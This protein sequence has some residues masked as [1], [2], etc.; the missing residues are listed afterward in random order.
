METIIE[1]CAGLDVHKDSIVAC[2]R[3]PGEQG[4]RR[5]VTAT[6]STTTSGLLTLHDWLAQFH[7]TIVAMESTGVYWKPIYYMLEDD[8]DCW[9]LNARHMRNVPG[10]KTDVADAAWIAQL[11][12]HG[13]ARPSFVPPREIRELRD[14]TRIARRSSPN[15][16]EKFNDCRKCLRTPAS[17]SHR[18][19]QMSRRKF[20]WNSSYDDLVGVVCA[21]GPK[22][23]R[24]SRRA[25]SRV[26][27]LR[28][29]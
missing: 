21:R 25:S 19:L 13:L 12:E 8:F 11:L 28:R 14:Y 24:S 9:L 17:S 10:R 20:V 1:R 7:V 18:W 5:S 23:A 16:V 22:N 26:M 6:F 27:C 4:A 29:G 15:A 2:V 3:T